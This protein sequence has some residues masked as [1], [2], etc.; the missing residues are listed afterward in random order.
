SLTSASSFGFYS[1]SSDFSQQFSSFEFQ[2]EE[3][4]LI[5]IQGNLQFRLR[6][7]LRNWDSLSV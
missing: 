7:S 3:L 5:L 6:N 1:I 4:N 2:I